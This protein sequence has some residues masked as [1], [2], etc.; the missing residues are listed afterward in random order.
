MN[1]D[2]TEQHLR[3]CTN[4]VAAFSMR[5]KFF[6]KAPVEEIHDVV[7]NEKLL[8]QLVI[9]EATKDLIQALVESYSRGSCMDD[10]V[11]GSILPT[12]NMNP[13]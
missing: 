3:I 12:S 1:G 2:L 10:F 11:E 13:Y 5:D 9:P 4:E 8:S 7:F 6:Y